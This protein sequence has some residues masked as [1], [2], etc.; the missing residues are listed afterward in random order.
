MKDLRLATRMR[1]LAQSDIRRMTLEC[2][3]RG[4]VNL[5]QGVCDLP[6]L[7]LLQ[8]GATEAI[9]AHRS[10]YSRYDGIAELRHHIARRLRDKNDLAYAED[11]EIV[12]TAGSTGAFAMAM[13]AFLDAGDEVIL[14]EPFYG[15]H[16]NT[17]LAA[18]GVPKPVPL[19]E[20]D[21][22]LDL[23][24][25]EQA[26]SPRTRMIVVCT[27]ANPCGKVWTSDELD[28][29]TAL[30][31]KHD[32]WAIT[33]EIYEDIL[34]DGRRHV[35]LASRPGA[36]ERTITV[37]GFSKTFSIT[38]WRLGFAA[39]P[40]PV[41]Q[42]IGILNDLFYVCAPT[43]LQHAVAYAFARVEPAYFDGLRRDY[44][45]KRDLLISVTRELGWS[46]RTPSGAY[47]LMVEPQVP[48]RDAREKADYVLQRSGV[49]GVPGSAFFADGGGEHLLRFSF[50]KTESDLNAAAA[51]LREAF[52]VAEETE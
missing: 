14:P 16:W 18:G 49:A 25:L 33:D 47:Y 52:L 22:A 21:F 15:Y 26:I 44:T 43:P 42:A 5:G 35:S 36:R 34:Y 27:P 24:A 3:R 45:R 32:L 11:G 17:I 4:G 8:E 9:A 1:A 7:P 51:R 12:V 41:A 50:A 13:M 23:T 19:S 10:T 20:P 38:G 37:S 6:T 31:R 39:A 40:Q 2:D 29:V 46:P 30:L 28:A 48:G